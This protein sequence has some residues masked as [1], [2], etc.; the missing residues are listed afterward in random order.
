MAAIFGPGVQ[1]FCYGQPRGT[2]FEG[3]IHGVTWPQY[4]NMGPEL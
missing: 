3:T 1:L 4:I 2:V